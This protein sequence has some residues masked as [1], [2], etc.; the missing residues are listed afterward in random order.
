MGK[1]SSKEAL[2]DAATSQNCK[3]ATNP[4]SSSPVHFSNGHTYDEPINDV[5]H[6]LLPGQWLSC[7]EDGV[8]AMVD[9]RQRKLMQSWRGHRKG[10]NCVLSAPR[11][12]GA[13][14]GGRDTLLKIWKENQPNPVGELSGHSLSVTAIAL[15]PDNNTLC[16]G[17]RDNCVRIWDLETAKSVSAC[18]GE[19]NVSPNR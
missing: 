16:S 17:S 7:G 4:V 5:V 11:L 8:V 9:W 12:S 19:C 1:C 14:S 6:G 15:S 18:D 13:V 10:V 2:G 3:S